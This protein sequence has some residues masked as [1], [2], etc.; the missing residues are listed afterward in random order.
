MKGRWRFC[1]GLLEPDK[2]RALD[3]HQRAVVKTVLTGGH[4]TDAH[5][6]ERLNGADKSRVAEAVVIVIVI[7]VHRVTSRASSRE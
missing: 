6:Q 3:P 5:N 2:G 1:K 4:L 7:P